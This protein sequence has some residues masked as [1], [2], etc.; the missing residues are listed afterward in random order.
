MYNQGVIS[1]IASIFNPAI[2]ECAAKVLEAGALEN[3]ETFFIPDKTCFFPEG[4]GQPSDAGFCRTG[5]GKEIRVTHCKKRDDGAILHF[6]D[7]AKIEAP[8]EHIEGAVKA[9]EA[10]ALSL[11]W[12]YCHKIRRYHTAL[13]VLCAVIWR[14]FGV[15]V[16]GSQ[17]RGDSARMDFG[18]PDWKPEYVSLIEAKVNGAISTGAPVKIYTLPAEEARKIPDLIRTDIDLLPEGLAEIRIVEIEGIDLQADGGPHVSSLA[19]VGAVRIVK[20]KN[21]GAGF[22]RLEIELA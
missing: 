8:G 2:R 12:E 6:F 14:E 7:F 9:G 4:G 5:D 22:R 20:V 18:F 15:K 10:I 13:H 3:G 17:S 16:T 11:D 19:E 1:Q 21:K